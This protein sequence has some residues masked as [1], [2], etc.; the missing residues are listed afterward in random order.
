M[1][2]VHKDDSSESGHVVEKVPSYKLKMGVRMVKKSK[3][4]ILGENGEIDEIQTD[5]DTHDTNDR[6]RQHNEM[7]GRYSER[8][9]LFYPSLRRFNE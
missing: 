1:E 9:S 7:S 2:K 3:Y 8:E 4:E 6:G 5:R